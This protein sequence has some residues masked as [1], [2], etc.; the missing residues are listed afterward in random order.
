MDNYETDHSS[1]KESDQYPQLASMRVTVMRAM[2][3]HDDLMDIDDMLGLLDIHDDS[4]SDEE[5]TEDANMSCTGRTGVFTNPYEGTGGT[6]YVSTQAYTTVPSHPHGSL[7]HHEHAPYSGR[8]TPSTD[9]SL[10]DEGGD[11]GMP[12][13]LAP[14]CTAA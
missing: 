5:D 12:A 3:D 6:T 1:G 8:S 13:Q 9:I 14:C 11:D 10:H 4:S 7:L 2:D